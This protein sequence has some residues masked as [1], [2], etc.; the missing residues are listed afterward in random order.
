MNPFLFAFC[1]KGPRTILNS[2]AL[3]SSIA[4][5]MNEE[6]VL[7][8]IST[9]NFRQ[10]FSD[11]LSMHTNLNLLV[12]ESVTMTSLAYLSWSSYTYFSEQK[13]EKFNTIKL[14]KENRKK[15]RLFISVVAFFFL[16]N[17]ENAV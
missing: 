12:A 6:I 17:V 16:R 13:M 4:T 15:I 3:V 14:F 5:E 2:H 10:Q 11:L 8:F 1:F 9:A 7:Q